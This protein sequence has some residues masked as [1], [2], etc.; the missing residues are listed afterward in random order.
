MPAKA[1]DYDEYTEKELL[2]MK[3]K[4]VLLKQL[5]GFAKFM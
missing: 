1:I 4:E 2:K 5:K 3:H